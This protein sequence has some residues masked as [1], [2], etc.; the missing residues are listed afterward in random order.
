[1]FSNIDSIL[2]EDCIN[3]NKNILLNSDLL[4][5]IYNKI[6]RKEIYEKDHGIHVKL[7]SLKLWQEFASI[8]TE[9]IITKCG[10]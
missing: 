3:K 10:R 8:G 6:L 2:D 9:M 4:A 5:D 7:E 1:M